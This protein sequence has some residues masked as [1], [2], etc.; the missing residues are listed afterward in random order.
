MAET[1]FSF[2]A[3]NFR[4]CQRLF[5]GTREQEYYLSDFWIEDTSTIAVTSE[6]CLLDAGGRGEAPG[7]E[8]LDPHQRRV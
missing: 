5:R 2:D 1:L 3:A 4:E 8:R 6:R 7:T